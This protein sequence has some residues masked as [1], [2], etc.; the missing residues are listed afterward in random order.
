MRSGQHGFSLVELML[1]LLVF[2]IVSGQMLAMS[3]T[4]FRTYLTQERVLDAQE[5][6][7]LVADMMLVDLRMA[8]FMIPAI[9]GVASVDGGAGAADILCVSDAG[10]ISEAML[11]D[12]TTRFAGASLTAPLGGSTG[13]VTLS[14]ADMDI[15][16]NGFDDFAV[17]GGIIISNGT[18]SHCARITTITGASNNDV[19]FVPV[20][21]GGFAVAPPTARAVPAH[22]Y[23]LAGGNLT[24][25]S[26]ALS[27]LVEDLQVEFGVDTDGDGQLGAGE[28]PIH[29]LNAS[30]PSALLS[31]RLSVLARTAAGDPDTMGLGRQAVANRA[32]AGAGD[33][34]KRRMVSVTATPPNLL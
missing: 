6:A 28:F 30:D 21:P 33:T 16:G 29:D 12:R 10:A 27:S 5:D 14:A 7:R 22:V 25:N 13:T 15:D 4:Q 9:T 31:V 3:S 26:L 23:E 2:A 19:G 32:A 8:G 1:A 24:R 17:G 34:F 11:T 18:Q 20:T